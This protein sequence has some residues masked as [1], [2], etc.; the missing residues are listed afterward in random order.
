MHHE[1]RLSLNENHDSYEEPPT[2]VYSKKLGAG[3]EMGRFKYEWDNSFNNHIRFIKI[4]DF[5]L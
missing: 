5:N 1:N 3:H 2:M 4:F